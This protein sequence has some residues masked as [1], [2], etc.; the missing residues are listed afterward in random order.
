MNYFVL[1]N[2]PDHGLLDDY[3]K[4]FRELSKSGIFVTTAVFCTLKDDDSALSKH[5]FKNETHCL[6]D[7]SYRNF[8]LE[9]RDQGHEIA[10]HGYSQVSDTRDEFQRG[11]ELFKDTF[12]EYP[13]VYIEHGGHPKSH[14][15]GLC[16]REN[17]CVEGSL[18]NS[19]YFVKDVVRNVFDLVWTHDYLLDDVDHPLPIGDIFHAEDGVVYFRRWRMVQVQKLLTRVAGDEKAVVGYTH[20]GYRGYTRRFNL[21][22]NFLNRDARLERWRGRHASRAV[23]LLTRLLQKYKL[24]SLTLSDLLQAAR[25]SVP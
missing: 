12:K 15:L 9:L 1:T 10:F 21:I 18:E 16:K 6:A 3:R 4:V 17:L 14:P 7:E 8:M 2:D 11:I 20:F 19:E 25:G 24:H 5:C 23:N 13:R 22:A